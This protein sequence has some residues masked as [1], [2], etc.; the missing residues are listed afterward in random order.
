MCDVRSGDCLTQK[1]S[2]VG[3]QT[4]QRYKMWDTPLWCVEA[5]TSA[6]LV[7]AVHYRM[8]W[9]PLKCYMRCRYIPAKANGYVVMNNVL[10]F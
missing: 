5:R 4:V 3:V 1:G 9:T 8:E 6:N 10:L 2:C 7:N